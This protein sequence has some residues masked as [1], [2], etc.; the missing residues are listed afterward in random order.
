MVLRKMFQIKIISP[1]VD[2]ME[3]IDLLKILIWNFKVTLVLSYQINNDWDDIETIFS[4]N[5]GR[6]IL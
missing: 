2:L 4:R 5:R 1:F 3:V 6:S